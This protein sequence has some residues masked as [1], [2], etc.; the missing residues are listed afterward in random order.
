MPHL[1]HKAR[2]GQRRAGLAQKRDGVVIAPQRDEDRLQLGLRIAPTRLAIAPFAAQAVV[3]NLVG[4]FI[5]LRAQFFQH[6]GLPV[7]DRFQQAAKINA[8]CASPGVPV[9]CGWP[10]NHS[11][12]RLGAKRRVTSRSGESTNP[13]ALERSIS[14]TFVTI[15]ML[16]VSTGPLAESRAE[17]SISVRS[18]WCGNARPVSRV[19]SAYS[20]GV[21]S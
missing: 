18:S 20:S 11:N 9:S 4:K 13:Q 5:Q 15:G 2:C 12:T 1:R 16:M 7:D 8:D 3:K 10:E 19:T 6:I 21:G 14:S 17:F